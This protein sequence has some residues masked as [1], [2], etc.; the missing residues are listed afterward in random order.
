MPPP[1]A[2]RSLLQR[3]QDNLPLLIGPALMVGADVIWLAVHGGNNFEHQALR[4]ALV[5]AVGVGALIGAMGHTIF[6]DQVAES[7]GWP[8]G[9]PFQ[10]EVGFANL[11][12]GVAGVM[13][14]WYSGRFWLA[15]IVVNS[16][17][18]LSDAGG[19]ILSMI[20]SRNFAPGNAGFV[21]W[22]DLALPILLCVLYATQ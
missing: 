10:L 19:H 8:M 17:F 5:F 1:S 2:R 15:V 11:S 7:I 13:C 6:R 16:I 9:S 20:K 18:L 21:F 4:N 14:A 12:Y 22:W 3:F